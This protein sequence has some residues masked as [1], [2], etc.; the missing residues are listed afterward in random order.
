MIFNLWNLSIVFRTSFSYT[1]FALSLRIPK[2][3]E[4]YVHGWPT[5]YSHHYGW[6][7]YWNF[8]FVFCP[9]ETTYSKI[10]KPY[11]VRGL[12]F[13]LRD[14][15]NLV[16]QSANWQLYCK[17]WHF[18]FYTYTKRFGIQA[19]FVLFTGTWKILFAKKMELNREHF[20]AI[21]LTSFDV[22]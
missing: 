13:I 6:Q 10:S 17:A 8:T 3:T 5:L 4:K 7:R 21:W 19:L 2:I 16:L 22:D 15:P 20:R 12:P 9:P 1:E 18:W 11:L 14:L